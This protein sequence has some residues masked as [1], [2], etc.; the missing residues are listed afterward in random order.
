MRCR[1]A[2]LYPGC[3]CPRRAQK[4]LNYMLRTLRLSMM[5]CTLL[6]GCADAA[7]IADHGPATDAAVQVDAAPQPNDLS[8]DAGTQPDD[9]SVDA[10]EPRDAEVGG[11][12]GEGRD[13]GGD[14][15]AD[16][17]PGTGEIERVDSD[18]DGWGDA[19]DNC[20]SDA[21]MDQADS[22]EDGVGDT[23]DVCPDDADPDQLD[24]DMNGV[25][26]ACEPAPLQCVG[27]YEF[28]GADFVFNANGTCRL[29]V[30]CTFSWVDSDTARVTSPNFDPMSFEV[31]FAPD[32]SFFTS[33]NIRANRIEGGRCGDGAIDGFGEVCDDG[34]NDDDLCVGGCSADCTFEATGCGD[35]VVCAPEECDDGGASPTCTP[36]CTIVPCG[37]GQLDEGEACDDGN[38]DDGDGCRGD[39]LGM[40]E[41]GDGLLDEG[42]GCDDANPDAGDGCDAVCAV[43]PGCLCGSPGD[44]C[45][46]A[47]DSES[48]YRLIWSQQSASGLVFKQYLSRSG[49]V[50]S[51][52]AAFPDEADA[53]QPIRV[54]G[55]LGTF[56]LRSGDRLLSAIGPQYFVSDNA[57]NR[58]LATT[59]WRLVYARTESQGERLRL[60]SLQDDRY[61]CR[62]SFFGSSIYSLQVQDGVCSWRFEG[63]PGVGACVSP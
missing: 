6:A 5:T 43:E 31:T 39:C 49:V 14:A 38:V 9:L 26:D 17:C 10:G 27:R 47:V 62:G 15:G 50:D 11:D 2:G 61:L 25:G 58:A 29:V 52:N 40:E 57:A 45:V 46:N 3:A 16:L 30:G 51:Y 54:V 59:Q 20:P 35:G 21:N 18:G 37:N 4:E 22:D 23:C 34:N 32:C 12:A 19:C 24:D 53:W 44:A 60:Q 13:A 55:E 8:V 36:Q 7:P 1:R 56:H 63:P 41:C 48:S 28:D 42:E 33:R